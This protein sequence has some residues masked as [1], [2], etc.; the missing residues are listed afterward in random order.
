MNPVEA[1][2]Q[3]LRLAILTIGFILEEARKHENA[4]ADSMAKRALF[5]AAVAKALER[6]RV[7]N[8]IEKQEVDAVDAA[9][10]AEEKKKT[11]RIV[12]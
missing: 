7:S 10:D 9:L 8:A 6:M 4:V 5:E 2:I 11:H 1:I 3:A 12:K